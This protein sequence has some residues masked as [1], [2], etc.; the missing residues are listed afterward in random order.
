[1]EFS[2]SEYLLDVEKR[3]TKLSSVRRLVFALWC[4]FELRGQFADSLPTCIG[5]KEANCLIQLIDALW[6]YVMVGQSLSIQTIAKVKGVYRVIEDPDYELGAVSDRTNAGVVELL[7]CIKRC[8][9]G[10]A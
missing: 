1:M 3:L 8:L 2:I 5:S 4:C 7:G 6:N 10:F 9:G